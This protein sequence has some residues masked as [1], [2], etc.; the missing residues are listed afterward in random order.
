MGSKVGVGA[1]DERADID[2]NGLVNQDD[3]EAYLHCLPIALMRGRGA[4]R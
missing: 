3:R 4:Q 2:S 1:Y